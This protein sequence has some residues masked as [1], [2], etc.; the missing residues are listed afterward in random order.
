[1]TTPHDEVGPRSDQTLSAVHMLNLHFLVAV[2]EALRADP[3]QASYEYG[4]DVATADVLRQAT[5]EGLRSLS[6]SLDRALF[7]LRVRGKELAGL[8]QKPSPLRGVLHAVRDSGIP[9][10]SYDG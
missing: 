4:I 10:Q 3:A 2:R 6:H 7:T 1:M 9:P 8:L 5:D